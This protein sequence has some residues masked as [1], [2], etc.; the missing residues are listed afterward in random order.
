MSYYC[1]SCAGENDL[2]MDGPIRDTLCSLCSITGPCYETRGLNGGK[3]PEM[4]AE[5]KIEIPGDE[6][7]IDPDKIGLT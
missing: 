4:M 7:K 5:K 1:L 3:E 6:I 2:P